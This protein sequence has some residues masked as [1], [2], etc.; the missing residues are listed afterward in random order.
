M[1]LYAVAHRGK[2]NCALEETIGKCVIAYLELHR[3]TA[4]CNASYVPKYAP[5]DNFDAG[6]LGQYMSQLKS[7][8]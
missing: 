6:I 7:K 8:G 3:K 1:L 2:V 4:I 5:L